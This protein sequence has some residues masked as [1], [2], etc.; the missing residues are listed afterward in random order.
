MTNTDY[1]AEIENSFVLGGFKKSGKIYAYVGSGVTTVLSLQYVQIEKQ[2]YV[3]VGF[4]LRRLGNACPGRVELTHLYYRLERLFPEH[5]ETILCA[6]KLDDTAQSSALVMFKDLIRT[7]M[8]SR[9]IELSDELQ[10]RHAFNEGLLVH[11][12]IRKEARDI[13][14]SGG[15]GS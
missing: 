14:Q 5:R 7:K 2:Y 9:L 6:G 4:W 8:A 15:D 11:G 1:K 3:N 12:L 10:L 13:L